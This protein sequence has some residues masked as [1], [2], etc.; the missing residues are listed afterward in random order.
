MKI[1]LRK[2]KKL[3]DPGNFY[4]GDYGEIPIGISLTTINEDNLD[5]SKDTKHYHQKGYEFYFTIK[6]KAIIEIKDKEVVLDKNHLIMVEPGEK[7]YVKKILKTPFSVLS[8]STL[9]DKTD[10]VVAK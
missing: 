8:I 3:R 6:G 2:D 4:F 1:F 9:K 7:H 5:E 10:K